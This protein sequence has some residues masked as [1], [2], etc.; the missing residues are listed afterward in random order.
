MKGLGS[1]SRMEFLFYGNETIYLSG[2]NFATGASKGFHSKEH[3]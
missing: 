3:K 2:H 1:R